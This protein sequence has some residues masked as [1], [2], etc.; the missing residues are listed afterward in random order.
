MGLG[1]SCVCVRTYGCPCL[2]V[3]GGSWFAWVRVG[4]VYAGAFRW[5]HSV[6]L[7]WVLIC[8]GVFRWMDTLS[9][10]RVCSCVL[11]LRELEMR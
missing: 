4:F 5:M 7:V 6:A 2:F 11:I 9:Q 3:S 1:G 10:V 8:A